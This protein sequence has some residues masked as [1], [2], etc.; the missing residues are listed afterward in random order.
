MAAIFVYIRKGEGRGNAWSSVRAADLL[1]THIYNI[2][3]LPK[4]SQ[5]NSATSTILNCQADNG[6]GT[7]QA[8]QWGRDVQ[9]RKLRRLTTTGPAV[10]FK[11]TAVGF[12]KI[13][14]LALF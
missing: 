3:A 14:S 5:C 7:E 1:Q 10:R 11:W 12:P 6:K 8:A 4:R 13:T 2:V 9:P